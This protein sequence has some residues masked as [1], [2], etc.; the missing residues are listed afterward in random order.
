[1]SHALGTEGRSHDRRHCRAAAGTVCALRGRRLHLEVAGTH[2][3]SL[4]VEQAALRDGVNGLASRM[5]A[6]RPFY[7][8]R[9]GLLLRRVRGQVGVAQ[10]RAAARQCDML[11]ASRQRVEAARMPMRRAR[12]S[13]CSSMAGQRRGSATGSPH[14]G[15]GRSGTNAHAPRARAGG[16]SSMAGRG[17]R[18]DRL[19]ASRQRAEAVGCNCAA[20]G[21]AGVAQWRDAGG[22]A[23]ARQAP[24]I[25]AVGRSGGLPTH[26]PFCLTHA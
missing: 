22:S 26:H 23:T 21:Q 13:G 17:R 6:G 24:H 11:H 7:A 5:Y 20:R 8:P 3:P 15:C 2:A 9:C 18:C 19:P 12:A 4:P 10:W 1:M 16:C 14:S 25:A